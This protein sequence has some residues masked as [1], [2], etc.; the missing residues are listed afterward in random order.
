MSGADGVSVIDVSESFPAEEEKREYPIDVTDEAGVNVI[1]QN[2]RS[3]PLHVN[4]T[5]F[6]SSA[7]PKAFLTEEDSTSG[8]MVT[9]PDSNEVDSTS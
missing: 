5:S 7:V 9:L 4:R 6:A 3:A 1:K 8:W 2:V